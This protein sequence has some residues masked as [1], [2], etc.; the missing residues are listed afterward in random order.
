MTFIFVG[1]NAARGLDAFRLISKEAAGMDQCFQFRRI[2]IRKVFRRLAPLEQR[3]S[4]LIHH[5]VGALRRKN[6]RNQKLKRILMVKRA[7]GVRIGRVEP[8]IDL[9]RADV[10]S[11]FWSWIL[12]S[13]LC[14]LCLFRLLLWPR[15]PCWSYC[16]PCHSK[17][18][19]WIHSCRLMLLCF[20][21]TICERNRLHTS[22][23][24]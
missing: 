15:L 13:C 11:P 17:W 14:R 10:L 4:D 8:L 3:W 12:T 24:L 22:R 6:G 20:R 7:L 21:Q 23:F 19:P 9:G 5:L 2:N 18:F 16:L 1:N